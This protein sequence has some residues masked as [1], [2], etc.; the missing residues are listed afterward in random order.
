MLELQKVA[1]AQMDY[2][3]DDHVMAGLSPGWGSCRPERAHAGE[4]CPA[5]GN[6][7]HPSTPRQHERHVCGHAHGHGLG[8]FRLSMH[9]LEYIICRCAVA[10]INR[11]LI[12]MLTAQ[13][14]AARTGPQC[15][16]ERDRTHTADHS[17]QTHSAQAG[18]GYNQAC[19]LLYRMIVKERRKYGGSGRNDLCAL[20]GPGH[21]CG[22]RW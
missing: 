1:A 13:S 17:P 12:Y 21:V 7:V 11:F 10:H 8:R 9:P 22:S 16:E 6:C 3:A 5:N 20:Q 18:S 2:G 14:R 4:S 19:K 15:A